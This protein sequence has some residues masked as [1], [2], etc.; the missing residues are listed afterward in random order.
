M[1]GLAHDRAGSQIGL[2]HRDEWKM[3]I[4][5]EELGVSISDDLK[6]LEIKGVAVPT[7]L[8]FQ[9][10]GQ[11]DGIPSAPQDCSYEITPAWE[12]FFGAYGG[13]VKDF[14]ALLDNSKS[15]LVHG[16]VY[17]L[18]ADV[19]RIVELEEGMEKF[20][21]VL[22][23][24]GH[25][26]MS[27]IIAVAPNRFSIPTEVDLEYIQQ[28]L[29]KE[30]VDVIAV[31]G[32]GADLQFCSRPSSI[33][34]KASIAVDGADDSAGEVI[35]PTV[36]SF[37]DS[38][39]VNDLLYDGQKDLVYLSYALAER[40]FTESEIRQTGGGK[41]ADDEKAMYAVKDQM[42]GQ[43]NL[44]DTTQDGID[45]L[46]KTRRTSTCHGAS[47]HTAHK[48]ISVLIRTT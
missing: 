42:A 44:A 20:R 35:F 22:D 14:T 23:R 30:R 3:R 32:S 26:F 25:G 46:T 1:T 33:I 2:V 5:K 41:G 9:V 34:G 11:I 40:L 47:D 43:L 13:L 28:Q 31:K 48:L 7:N 21:E 29:D 10:A 15:A 16:I 12:S 19:D 27:V 36:D 8:D 39:R 45:S 37:K 24:M 17:E 4:N 18:A 6:T 38:T